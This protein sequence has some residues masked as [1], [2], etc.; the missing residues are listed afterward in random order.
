[1]APLALSAPATR[2]ATLEAQVEQLLRRLDSDEFAERDAATVELDRLPVEALPLLEAAIKRSNVSPDVRTALTNPM[3]RMRRA[4]V[5]HNT[6]QTYLAFYQSQFVGEYERAGQKD[7][8]WDTA[9]RRLLEELARQEADE[10]SHRPVS[11]AARVLD[12]AAAVRK[13]KPADPVLRALAMEY[14]DNAPPL[15]PAIELW[16][17]VQATNYSAFR[18]ASVV[19]FVVRTAGDN[20]TP[21]SRDRH[22]I[23]RFVTAGA[24][25]WAEILRDHSFP[26]AIAILHL[27]DLLTFSRYAGVSTQEAWTILDRRLTPVLGEEHLVRL[28]VKGTYLVNLADEQR[29]KGGNGWEQS[30][31]TIEEAGRTFQRIYE[32]YPHDPHAPTAMIAVLQRNHRDGFDQAELWFERAT[33]ADPDHYP[34]WQL[35]LETFDTDSPGYLD[36]ARQALAT[37]SFETRIPLIIIEV[38]EELQYLESTPWASLVPNAYYARADVWADVSTAYE[39]FLRAN[40]DADDD[41]RAYLQLA[42][43]GG[44]WSTAAEQ[45]AI[46]AQRPDWAEHNDGL[47]RL[48]GLEAPIRLAEPKDRPDR[49]AAILQRDRE[50]ADKM[51]GRM[52]GAYEQLGR[53]NP[54]WDGPARQVLEAAARHYAGD[55]DS[56]HDEIDTILKLGRVAID[57]GCDD[58]LVR[59]VYYAA[60]DD[61]VTPAGE[62]T[63]SSSLD[64]AAAVMAGGYEPY[65]R[66][67]LMLQAIGVQLG[68]NRDADSKA[69]CLQQLEAMPPLL[70]QLAAEKS[71]RDEYI[72]SRAARIVQYTAEAGGNR[73]AMYQRVRK[74]LQDANVNPVMLE[75][76]R[77]HHLFH[78]ARETADKD[79]KERQ[80]TLVRTLCEQL[81]RARPEA[82]QPLHLLRQL[83]IELHDTDAAYF[84]ARQSLL[85]DPLDWQAVTDAYYA[86]LDDNAYDLALAAVETNNH[87]AQLPLLMMTYQVLAS[88][89]IDPNKP[90]PPL[91]D[92]DKIADEAVWQEIAA[93]YEAYLAQFPGDSD[94]RSRYASLACRAGRWVIADAQIRLLGD[95]LRPKA[96]VTTERLEACKKKAEAMAK[97]ATPGGQPQEP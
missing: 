23:K 66:L 36:F 32:L 63:G 80:L 34:A 29:E 6:Y 51:L 75:E 58:P 93:V 92:V 52:I 85:A 21:S 53:K 81:W 16:P 14:D 96:F 39:G 57:N 41:R 50:D 38:H 94:Q 89:D 59:Q 12:A 26:P 27:N 83:A 67:T 55:P 62:L 25:L 69:K 4:V 71:T 72:V 40:P 10:L 54:R 5:R 87:P 91:P 47:V 9:A 19:R 82:P 42:Y 70:R 56:K 31:R 15:K 17:K 86:G 77:A 35:R 88:T 33:R 11:N 1:M 28:N 73:E 43:A 95:R 65:L 46:L 18:K 49:T 22:D 97:L 76:L 74:A 8:R 3:A 37:G 84:W 60:V 24:E 45:L 78:L 13:L 30:L 64:D 68:V 2:P 44:H 48:I 20:Q 61:Y 79:E 7:P 90:I